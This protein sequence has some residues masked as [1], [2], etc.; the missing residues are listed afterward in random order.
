[1]DSLYLTTEFLGFWMRE[2]CCRTGVARAK[3]GPLNFM[4][5]RLEPL[6]RHLNRCSRQ[7]HSEQVVH[8]LPDIST[9]SLLLSQEFRPL[10]LQL[11]S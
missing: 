8:K 11:W 2:F 6:C 5:D 3:D 4:A 7:R 1:M 10:P 9:V